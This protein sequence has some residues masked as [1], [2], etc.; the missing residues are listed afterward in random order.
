M[1]SLKAS[2]IPKRSKDNCFIIVD[3]VALKFV[4]EFNFVQILFLQTITKKKKKKSI[5]P[6]N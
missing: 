5:N 3:N 6:N 1:I 2:T 4:R